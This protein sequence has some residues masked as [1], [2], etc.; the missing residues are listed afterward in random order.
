MSE[1]FAGYISTVGG[2]KKEKFSSFND[3]KICHSQMLA[4][5]DS[6]NKFDDKSLSPVPLNLCVI[7]LL[8]SIADSPSHRRFSPLQ[9]MMKTSLTFIL[10]LVSL[11]AFFPHLWALSVVAVLHSLC[12]KSNSQQQH[13]G[14]T[15]EKKCDEKS[16]SH[17]SQW[18]VV[19]FFIHFH[20]FH[21]DNFCYASWR[22]RDDS[23]KSVLC[24]KPARVE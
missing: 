11:N 5:V 8:S 10:L 13:N 12:D 6:H 22:W 23:A 19:I 18:F 21:D 20:R 17:S 2:R 4:T 3:V 24:H 9:N 1:Q 14:E 16:L 15:E 7:Y